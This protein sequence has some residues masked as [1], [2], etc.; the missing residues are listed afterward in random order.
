MEYRGVCTKTRI[1]LFHQGPFPHGTNNIGEFLALVHGL[2]MLKKQNSTLPVYSD[3]ITAIAW[4]RAKKC[5]SKLEENAKMKLC[6][7]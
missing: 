3:S 4:V 1:E 7:N 6:L 5:K 2:A